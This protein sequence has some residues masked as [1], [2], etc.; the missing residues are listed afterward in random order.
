MSLVRWQPQGEIQS[1]RTQMDRLF[2]QMV[3]SFFGGMPAG[4]PAGMHGLEEARALNPSFEVYTT[5]DAVV[6]SAELAGI[7]PK[8]V[9]VEVTPDAVHVSGELKRES[10]IKDDDYYH[11][12]RSY[13][14]FERTVRLPYRVND[15]EAKATFKHG[16]LTIRMPLA[17]AAD[18]PRARKLTIVPEEGGK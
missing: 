12:E 10:E 17:D 1:I 16:V 4:I 9:D 18:R 6:V 5:E 8:E 13:G 3:G 2:D 7:D 11:S 14:R 15:A